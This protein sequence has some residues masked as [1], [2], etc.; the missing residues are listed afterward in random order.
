MNVEDPARRK[1]R[2]EDLQ[3]A[4]ALGAQDRTLTV[5]L[6]RM[7]E[8][9]SKTVGADF[10]AL[11]IADESA[12]A[13][14]RF[15]AVDAANGSPARLPGASAANADA[16]RIAGGRL[17]LN[18]PIRAQDIIYA[19]LRLSRHEGSPGFTP[20]DEALVASFAELAGLAIDN[21][22]RRRHWL[23]ISLNLTR[24]LPAAPEGEAGLIVQ[25]AL[26]AS[27]A[28]LVLLASPASDDSG[29][30]CRA[31]A[32][33][34][35][36]SGDWP[37]LAI[38]PGPLQQ[39]L[40]MDTPLLCAAADLL[41][42]GGEGLAAAVIAPVNRHS[43]N[44]GLLILCRSAEADQFPPVDV[45]MTGVF[46]E[47]V[48]LALE[49]AQGQRSRE[50]LMLFTD[51]D[52]IARDLNDL[53]IQRLFAA[54]LEMQSLRRFTPDETVQRRI[55]DL[56]AA[57][58]D[59]IRQVRDSIY[60]LSPDPD[61]QES[62]SAR[63]VRVVHEATSTSGCVPHLQF[64]GLVDSALLGP[65]GRHLLAVLT[66]G[67]NNAVH[68]SRAQTISICVSATDDLISLTIDDDG[69]GVT[70][71]GNSG[72]LGT[73]EQQARALDA[74]LTVS[75]NPGQGTHLRWEAPAAANNRRTRPR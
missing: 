8:F 63:I 70:V 4:T 53:V 35:A 21:A 55:T 72:R 32:G 58:D 36:A 9:C 75:S 6:E 30:R 64:E 11:E 52:R 23:R 68:H 61:V 29:P 57:V 71:P 73:L 3:A 47:H 16:D 5:A 37:N 41:N 51:R 50:Q 15:I 65:A 18:V 20:R 19:H 40:E 59:I 7:V 12:D 27:G 39:A 17:S 43:P 33:P 67:L 45:D 56:T 31:V 66:E 38:N 2:L 54:G 28:D 26:A 34:H 25:H 24:D 10:G 60:A 69:R 1:S 13:S 22:W 14:G 62:L 74:T 49:L 48:S 44:P 46:C 42:S